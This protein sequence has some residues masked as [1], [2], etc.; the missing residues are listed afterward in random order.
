VELLV[1][2]AIIALLVA[3]L[4]PAVQSAREAARRTQCL[5]QLRQV[6]LALLNHEGAHNAFPIG[7][8][9]AGNLLFNPPRTTWF[10]YLFPYMELGSIYDRFDFGQSPGPGAAVWTNPRNATGPNAATP[11]VVSQLLCPSDGLG[12]T[13]HRHPT[14]AGVFARANYAGFFG[15][16]DA[17][18]MSRRAP[19]HLAAA[20]GINRG[21]KLRHMRDGVSKTMVFGEYLT[22]IGTSDYD[23]RGV[24]WYDHSGCSQLYTKV[25]PNASVPDILYPSWCPTP[26]NRPE[27]NLPCRPG[28]S[29]GSDN[30][31]TARSRHPGGVHVAHGDGSS[32]LARDD[33]DLSVWQALGSI[34]GQDLVDS[35]E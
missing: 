19:P 31:A 24:L 25:G 29:N 20:F 14:V 26:V 33:V 11:L 28:S 1:V 8:Q 30:W 18:R 15:N 32:R 23:Y 35:L 6:T 21:V 27:L 34:D 16:F 3:L 9:N 22:G 4:L 7:T 17:G 2:I 13:T 12:G 10:I 5:N